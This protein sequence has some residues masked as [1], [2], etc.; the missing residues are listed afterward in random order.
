M[1]KHLL[2]TILGLGVSG[3][4]DAADESDLASTETS[5]GSDE[6]AAAEGADGTE[7]QPPCVP[8]RSICGPA[9]PT[10]GGLCWITVPV[11]CPYVRI[12]AWGG[13]AAG[14]SR[15][16]GGGGFAEL[17]MTS[18]HPDFHIN[19]TTV[20]E[21]AVPATAANCASGG[22]STR[23]SYLHGGNPDRGPIVVMAGGGGGSGIGTLGSGRGGAG[24]G[25]GG[26][27]AT[28]PTTGTAFGGGPGTST[29]VGLGGG[30]GG[31][32][33]VCYAGGNG[34]GPTPH[35]IIGHLLGGSGGTGGVSFCN[36]SGGQGGSGLFG[37]GGGA[38][39]RGG[40]DYTAGGGGGG[41]SYVADFAPDAAGVLIGGTWDE[42]GRSGD[43]DRGTAGRGGQPGGLPGQAGRVVVDWSGAPFPPD[44]VC[45]SDADC[46]AGTV[47]ESC[48]PGTSQCIT[49][50]RTDAGCGSGQTCTPIECFACPCAD[51]CSS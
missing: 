41:S 11:G 14:N 2:A 33:T 17:R 10:Q 6:S 47:C 48:G 50:C 27:Q 3:C 37:G 4:L 44:E 18:P 7:L 39:S 32:V 20:L 8:G 38:G 28:H 19:G 45:T 36:V 40:N 15:T 23:V 34:T 49:G 22:G 46:G 12:K 13:G 26:E 1:T 16:G 21:A 30:C 9:S 35:S 42:P 25:Q 29:S 24:G 31:S 43:P 51:T 5:K